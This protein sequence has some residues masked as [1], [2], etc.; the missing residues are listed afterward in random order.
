ML[1]L[2]LQFLVLITQT[3]AVLLCGKLKPM[4]APPNGPVEPYFVFSP[5]N[6][7]RAEKN[8]N[9]LWLRTYLVLEQILQRLAIWKEHLS[10]PTKTDPGRI[11]LLFFIHR[12]VKTL[13]VA[14]F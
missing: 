1:Y 14:H 2:A 11:S 4:A 6:Q 7:N 9:H 5:N 10:S 12:R 13:G 3:A 8:E